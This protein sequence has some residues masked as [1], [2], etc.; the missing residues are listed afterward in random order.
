MFSIRLIIAPLFFVSTLAF[1]EPN[2]GL[3]TVDEL[4]ARG[5]C[6]AAVD[7]AYPHAQNGEPWAQYR[8][9]AMYGDEKCHF[10]KKASEALSWLK[11]AALYES[12]TDWERG[13]QLSFLG[14]TGF[15][16]A[17]T[18]STKAA[19]YLAYIFQNGNYLEES[20]YW[21]NRAMSQYSETESEFANLERTLKKFEAYIPEQRL[22]ALKACGIAISCIKAKI[23]DPP[24]KPLTANSSEH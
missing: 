7:V 18:A 8:V 13:S 19:L 12:K 5:E 14:P 1:A 4:F 3:I 10:N 17:R 11:A 9:G 22:A 24:L 20:W 16:N 2:V 23:P 6:Q 21:V 15:F